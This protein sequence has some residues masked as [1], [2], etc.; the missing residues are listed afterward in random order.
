MM[1]DDIITAKIIGVQP[2]GLFVEYEHYQGLIHISE[3]SDFYVGNLKDAF[4]VGQN[5]EVR[6]IDVN[7]EKHQLHLSYK[8]ANK[9]SS[10]VLKQVPIVTGF[11]TLFNQLELWINTY[12]EDK[13]E[14]KWKKNTV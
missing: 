12:R 6:V 10:K 5:I 3:I 4:L 7:E 1:L 9:I 11:H 8:K 14:Q 13:G 2:Y